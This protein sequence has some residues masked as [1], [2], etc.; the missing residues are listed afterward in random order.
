MLQNFL[1]WRQ[2]YSPRLGACTPRRANACSYRTLALEKAVYYGRTETSSSPTHCSYTSPRISCFFIQTS[3]I[4]RGISDII[5]GYYFTPA[6]GIRK[7]IHTHTH[8][9]T[10]M[11]IMNSGHKLVQQQQLAFRNQTNR[12]TF[13]TKAWQADRSTFI[14]HN[15]QLHVVT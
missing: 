4:C 12:T 15:E 14:S 11:L 7:Y 5:W 1:R 6:F 2:R 8:H 13:G 3:I 10:R 9:F